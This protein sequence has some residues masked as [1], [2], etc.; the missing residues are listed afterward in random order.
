MGQWS[1]REDSALRAAHAVH[2]NWW[3]KCAE[4]MADALGPTWSERTPKRIGEHW[5]KTCCGIEADEERGIRALVASFVQSDQLTQIEADL[6]VAS[7]RSVAGAKQKLNA[8]LSRYPLR[9]WSQAREHSRSP[10]IERL[11]EGT[12]TM[13]TILAFPWQPASHNMNVQNG[14]QAYRRQGKPRQRWC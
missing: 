12:A 8:A 7:S 1:E 6:A 4:H 3:Q 9:T 13:L 11:E 5:R 14:T 10:M 2:G